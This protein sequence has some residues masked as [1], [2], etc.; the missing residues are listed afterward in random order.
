MDSLASARNNL[1]DA[2]ISE[3]EN[4]GLV[5]G[6]KRRSHRRRHSRASARRRSHHR[7]RRSSRKSIGGRRHSKRH[8]SKHRASKRRSSRRSSRHMAR[9]FGYPLGGMKHRMM[10]GGDRLM[11]AL[12][13][14]AGKRHSRR[15][16]HIRHY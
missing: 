7:S 14:A 15:S 1:L 12:A 4:A 16:R 3:F 6:A 9:G 11:Y 5:G 13:P 2:T 10:V 8:S